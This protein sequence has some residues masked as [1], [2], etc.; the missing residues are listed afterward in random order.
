MK[1]TDALIASAI[2]GLLSLPAYVAGADKPIVHCFERER[3]YGVVKAGQ[4]DCATAAEHCVVGIADLS[5]YSKSS[6]GPITFD[7]NAPPVPAPVVTVTPD[8]DL[9][10]KQTVTVGATGFAGGELVNIGMARA[11]ISRSAQQR[12]P[13]ET[14]TSRSGSTAYR[15]AA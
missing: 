6:G 15:A 11:A 7:P 1:K 9:V 3:C 13:G 14:V 5:D 2:A 4:N 10:D 12:P 8:S